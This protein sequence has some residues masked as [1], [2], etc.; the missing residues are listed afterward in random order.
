ML[1]VDLHLFLSRPPTSDISASG[2]HF[3]QLR[4]LAG[5]TWVADGTHQTSTLSP[6][7]L[8][9]LAHR[10]TKEFTPC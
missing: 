9:H 7:T 6:V 8:R 3:P 4:D 5:Y 10:G 2:F 1:P